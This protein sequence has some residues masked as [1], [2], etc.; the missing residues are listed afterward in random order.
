MNKD[1]KAP[2][3]A[4]QSFLANL[5]QFDPVRDNYG[6]AVTRV[7]EQQRWKCVVIYFTAEGK[8]SLLPLIH[9]R[10]CHFFVYAPG[11]NP[12]AVRRIAAG[13]SN[14]SEE[15]ASLR[16][17]HYEFVGGEHNASEAD[18]K[19]RIGMLEMIAVGD[20]AGSL[21]LFAEKTSPP[22]EKDK[23]LSDAVAAGIKANP[24]FG[25]LPHP[26]SKP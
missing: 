24:Q 26:G 6:E 10:D 20:F 7:S 5:F 16:I 2:F 25:E 4:S 18:E 19:L 9:Q 23:A 15:F 1:P 11:I 21:K 12:N 8:A 14:G 17:Y 3:L 13:M 22:S